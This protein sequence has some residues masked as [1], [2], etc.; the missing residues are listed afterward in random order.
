MPSTGVR[1][2]SRTSPR[3]RFRELPSTA[4]TRCPCHRRSVSGRTFRSCRGSA[5]GV[6]DHLEDLLVQGLEQLLVQPGPGTADGGRRH[7]SRLWQFD[8]HR[9]ALPPQFG[10]RGRISRTP[11]R[12]HQPEHE[13][14][15]HQRVQ[16]APP[17]LPE[18]VVPVGDTH[19]RLDDAA[20]EPD[21]SIL[22]G[23]DRHRRRRP[24]GT[25]YG[26]TG[27]GQQHL[28]P[29]FRQRIQVNVLRSPA[30]LRCIRL[31]SLR[32]ANALPVGRTVAGPPVLRRIH[33]GLRQY[34]LQAVPLLPVP[35]Q[36]PNRHRQGLRGQIR[37][38]NPRENQEP[39]VAHHPLQT[40][41][42]I[43]VPPANPGV[44][45]GKPSRARL[46]QQTAQLATP[47][48]PQPVAQETAE[49][50]PVTQLMMPVHPAPS[51]PSTA[52]PSAHNFQF[53]RHQLLQPARYGGARI[54]AARMPRSPT[55]GSRSRSRPLR[56]QRHDAAGLQ[57]LQHPQT[58]TQSIPTL[59]L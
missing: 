58:G 17:P 56:R 18:P 44:T 19:E 50:M 34:R 3:G 21:K 24:A 32:P 11:L 30:F 4:N 22:R 23:Q 59:R 27:T 1:Q 13:Q 55:S 39:G 48:I 5:F 54:R 42:P 29:V 9:P 7:R 46:K 28:L 10:Q 25:A 37:N 2:P 6:E 33:E 45:T 38:P 41:R 53:Q 40:L 35:G 20:P 57:L 26:S 15:D 52:S 49:R 14:H 47:T 43:P 8:P 12:E 16:H 51:I 36:P 31:A